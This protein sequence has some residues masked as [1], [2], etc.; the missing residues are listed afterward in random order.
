MII[1]PSYIYIYIY[2]MNGLKKQTAYGSWEGYFGVYCSITKITLEWTNKQFITGVHALIYFLH[3][4][5]NLI[6]M[7]KTTIFTHQ[8]RVSI[9][10]FTF[11]TIDCWWCHKCITRCTNSDVHAKICIWLI[12]YRFH[13]WPYSQLSTKT[14][15]GVWEMG[16]GCISKTFMSS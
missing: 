11:C 15:C 12:K 13:S 1:D 3:D 2:L 6:I 9:T 16:V 8:S 10:R 5:M 4:I 7:T 14:E